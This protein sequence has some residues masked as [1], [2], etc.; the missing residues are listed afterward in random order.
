M[1][2][3]FTKC[4]PKKRCSIASVTDLLIYNGDDPAGGLKETWNFGL[5]SIKDRTS[6]RSYAEICEKGY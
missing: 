1:N 5:G 3:Y 2:T 6:I 4:L